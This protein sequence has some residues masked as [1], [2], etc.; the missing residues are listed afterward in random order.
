V[1]ASVWQTHSAGAGAKG[2]RWYAWALIQLTDPH[3]PGQHALLIRRNDR[4]SE[5][6]F[7]RAYSPTLVPLATLVRVAGR[8][9]AIEEAFQ[10]GKGLAGLDEHQVHRWT[11]WHRATI[12]SMPPMPCSPSPPPPHGRAHPHPVDPPDRQRDPAPIHR[13]TTAPPAGDPSR[14]ALVPMATT[15]PSQSTRIPLST[16]GRRT[17]ITNYRWSIRHDAHPSNSE[18]CGIKPALLNEAW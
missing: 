11:S 16:T 15:T 12:L 17:M 3:T 6:A 13:A 10:A 14:S 1:P 8:R 4:T 7:Y 18:R 9:W 2:H 5:H